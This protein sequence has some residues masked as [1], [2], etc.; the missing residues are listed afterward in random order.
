MGDKNSVLAYLIFCE[1]GNANRF[2]DVW[3][4]D[5]LKDPIAEIER[6]YGVFGIEFTPEA[7]AGMEKWRTD[8]P[9]DKRPP[10]EYRLEDYG[11][12]KEGIE[13]AFAEYRE[14]FI[15]PRLG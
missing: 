12:T 6:A 8:N 10:H 3:F 15:V 14:R 9:R 2:V 4:R 13:A 11:L 7:R 1:F 5:A